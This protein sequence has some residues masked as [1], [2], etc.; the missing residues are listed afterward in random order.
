M[1]FKA[2]ESTNWIRV[3]I[4]DTLHLCVNK[5]RLNGLQA[6]RYGSEYCIEFYYENSSI[7]CSYDNEDMWKEILNLFS[8]KL[9]IFK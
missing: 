1:T 8:D 5:S 6:W 7:F 3:F 2:S 4:N 9:F